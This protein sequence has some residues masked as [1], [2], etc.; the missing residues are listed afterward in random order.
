[1]A[2]TVAS[3]FA[4]TKADSQSWAFQQSYIERLMDHSALTSAHPDDTLVLAGPPRMVGP[5]DAGGATFT[6]KLLPL[7]MVQQMQ[8][9][10]NKPT[11]PM[12]AIGTGRLFFVSGKA[13]G[14]AS[15]ARLFVN[16]RNLLRAL[17]TN[18]VQSGIDPTKFDDE[19]AYNDGSENVSK[20]FA[21]LDS[22]L[23]LI[24]FGLAVFFRDKIHDEVGAFYLELC[25]LS[26]WA[27]AIGAG[28]TMILENVTMMFDRL[29]P[30]TAGDVGMAGQSRANYDPQDAS[31]SALFQTIFQ[32]TG[33]SD[34]ETGVLPENER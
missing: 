7:G 29:R 13:Q 19:A 8:V 6:S 2:N 22:E 12:Q 31:N 28:Q 18:A 32:A 10:Q 23:F 4:T 15:I 24:P 9:A 20:F 33:I 14:T 17:Y 11:T 3:P 25:A 16:G 26:T 21:N 5:R 34:D 1:M 27:I 30:Y